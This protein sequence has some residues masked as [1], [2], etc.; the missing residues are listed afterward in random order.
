MVSCV[1]LL[2]GCSGES[3]ENATEGVVKKTVELAKGAMTGIDKGIEHGRK[4]AE[5]S[6]GAVVVSTKDELEKALKVEI[7]SVDG[8]PSEGSTVIV[9]GFANNASAPVRVTELSSRGAVTLLDAENY[10]CESRVIPYEF[11]VPANAK[12]KVTLSFDCK[13]DKLGKL[14]LFG[15]D[16]AIPAGLI[17]PA[18]IQ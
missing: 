9:A 7:L 6:D 3:A 8:G 13:S 2:S 5:S 18:T 17:K 16:I 10:A 11:T 1:S 12:Q 15:G 4:A 14:R